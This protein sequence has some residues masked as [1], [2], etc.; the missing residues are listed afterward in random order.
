MESKENI[1]LLNKD[2]NN[3]KESN[4]HV[5]NNPNN[6]NI[7][8]KENNEIINFLN[9]LSFENLNEYY[10][11]E[12]NIFIKRI[13]KLNLKFFWTSESIL[14]KEEI[15]YPY[16]KLFLILFKQI[17]LYIEEIARLNKLLKLKNKNE[18]YMKKII[19][20]MK[21][22][23]KENILNKQM[24]KNL[25][26]NNKI[27]EKNI[28]K[29]KHEIEKLTK[30]LYKNIKMD[31]NSLTN[32]LFL[33]NKYKNNFFISN[34][35]NLNVSVGFDTIITQ[36]SAYSKKNNSNK[37]S[38][39][40]I[41]SN[42]NK[43]KKRKKISNSTDETFNDIKNKIINKGILQ[44]DEDIENLEI[45]EDILI[46]FKNKNN[47]YICNGMNTIRNT[48]NKNMYNKNISIYN[49]GIKKKNE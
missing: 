32:S 30:K 42:D 39:I 41:L 35:N 27:L 45:I 40:S 15:K 19:A 47:K 6:K 4:I 22:K 36:A 14:N 38:D 28:D 46:N 31:G 7:N 29:N 24:V 11:I 2:K 34:P 20:K 17:S 5:I 3:K 48:Y 37:L 9:S 26:R 8:S 23:E 25:Q 21:E 44:C 49:K 16:N 13:E 43:S 33:N 1:E 12:S 18:N 10:D